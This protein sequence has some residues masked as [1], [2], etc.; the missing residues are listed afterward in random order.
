M[1][2]KESTATTRLNGKRLSEKQPRLHKDAV[3]VVDLSFG[4]VFKQK[5]KGVLFAVYG[6]GTA[7]S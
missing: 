7:L 4:K 2:V 5:F 3:A 6:Q 1:N